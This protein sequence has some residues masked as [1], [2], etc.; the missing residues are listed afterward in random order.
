MSSFQNVCYST[1]FNYWLYAL[2][3]SALFWEGL[4]K[5]MKWFVSNSQLLGDIFLSFPKYLLQDEYNNQIKESSNTRKFRQY[6]HF[7]D[8]IRFIFS[9]CLLPYYSQVSVPCLVLIQKIYF[10]FAIFH[11]KKIL[12]YPK[13]LIWEDCKNYTKEHPYT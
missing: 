11:E 6:K 10:L 1:A 4:Y 12:P 5:S 8:E 13:Y 3:S 7:G 9:Q 2:D